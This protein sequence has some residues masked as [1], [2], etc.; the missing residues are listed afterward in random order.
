[1]ATVSFELEV[2]C[3]CG[4]TLDAKFVE[5]VRGES[6]IEVVP[7]EKC[8]DAKWDEGHDEGYK[9]GENDAS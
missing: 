8:L 3:E 2:N 7:C 5:P 9:E 4:E 1:M 6:Y